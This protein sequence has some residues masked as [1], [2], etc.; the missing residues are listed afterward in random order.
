MNKGKLDP[1]VEAYLNE[2]KALN[3]P[4]LE[5]LTPEQARQNNIDT[6]KRIGGQLKPIAKMEDHIVPTDGHDVPIRIYTPEGEGPFPVFVY[7][8]GGGW[9]TGD[10]N[11]HDA[12]CC[13]L[14]NMTPCMV[15]T[16]D[17]RLAPEHKFPAAV[18]DAISSTRWIQENISSFGGS[19]KKIA[20]GGDSAGG[21]LATVVAQHVDGLCYQILMYPVIDLSN[22][23]TNSYRNFAE[24][25]FLTRNS[26]AWFRDH[27]LKDEADR[28]HPDASPL[29]Y[30]DLS[31]QPPALVL[32]AGFDPLLDEGEAY[33]KRL[34]ASG[35]SVEYICYE[36]QVHGFL[37][38]ADVVDAA[39]VGLEACAM[40]LQKVFSALP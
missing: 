24:G 11:T 6:K 29:L 2:L 7:F 10:L 3:A 33:A 19:H 15:V 39:Y 25:Y 9:V 8:H 26:M 31:N 27:Y 23:D 30:D 28:T 18:N 20:I 16:V 32:T 34:K 13:F 17:Y 14:C 21:N 38:M 40:S 1:Q 5:T 4:P 22:L 36:G 12:L 35:V 37:T